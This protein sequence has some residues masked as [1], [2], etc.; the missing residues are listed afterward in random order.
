[1]SEKHK[2]VS[3]V[4]N[5]F[6]H[7]L[8]FISAFSGCVSISVFALLF[9]VLAVIASSTLGLKI[10]AITA[11]IKTYKPIFLYFLNLSYVTMDSDSFWMLFY[12]EHLLLN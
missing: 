8:I 4:L 6:E 3:R 11:R 5:C 10:C 7:F 9:S 1:M 12:M 2:Q